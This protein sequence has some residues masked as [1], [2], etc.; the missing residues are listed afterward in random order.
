MSHRNPIVQAHGAPLFHWNGVTTGTCNPSPELPPARRLSV[1]KV[2]FIISV[3]AAALSGVTALA[4]GDVPRDPSVVV[5][6]NWLEF[7][8]TGGVLGL[9]IV[10]GWWA[11]KKD[12]EARESQTAMVTMSQNV[13]GQLI[14]M[15]SNL[16]EA[17]T[18]MESTI[19]GLKEAVHRLANRRDP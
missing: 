10:T 9:A 11:M 2:M 3:A 15:V 18:R 16:T 8:R 19:D 17:M 7:F 13:Q 4:Q 5:A 12:A 6:A 1:S 14:N